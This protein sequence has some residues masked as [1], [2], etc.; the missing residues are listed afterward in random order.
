MRKGRCSFLVILSEE[1]VAKDQS[2]INNPLPM[3][4]RANTLSEAYRI[5]DKECSDRGRT[6]VAFRACAYRSNQ[7]SGS[8]S[9]ETVAKLLHAEFQSQ[10]NTN[11]N[12]KKM[13][14]VGQQAGSTLKDQLAGT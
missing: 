8:A 12:H 9:A 5:A 11:M 3:K 13:N 2:I 7:G 10:Q 4:N 1:R 14:T 6:V